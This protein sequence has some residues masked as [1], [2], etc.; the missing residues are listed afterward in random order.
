MSKFYQIMNNPVF[1]FIGKLLDVIVLHFLWIVC[2][3]PIVTF[4]ASTTALYYALMKE[5]EDK[6]GHYFRQFFKSFKMNLKQGIGVGLIFIFVEGGLLYSAYLCSANIDLNPAFGV[7]RIIALVLAVLALLIFEYV[8]PLLARFDNT[9]VNTFKNAFLFA[10]RYF[11]WTLVMAAMIVGFYV[12]MYYFE[13]Y[14][15]PLMILG[16][17]L[18]AFGCAYILNRIFKPYID[19]VEQEEEEKREKAWEEREKAEAA[20]MASQP[21]EGKTE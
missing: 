13:R 17:G 4:G 3:L 10:I 19:A 9:L 21:E 16:F 15:F 7:I 14:I 12:L 6:E 2:S 11:G 20:A 18:P 1:T 8:F 5:A